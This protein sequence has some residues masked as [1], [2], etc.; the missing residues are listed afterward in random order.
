MR[1]EEEIVEQRQRQ[2]EAET[3]RL[4]MDSLMDGMMADGMTAEQLMT[5]RRERD[6]LSIRLAQL[7]GNL[8]EIDVCLTT[9]N[10]RHQ[11]LF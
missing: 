8:S 9:E 2:K 6:A 3:I 5:L 11:M 1:Y 10:C 4:R 7:T